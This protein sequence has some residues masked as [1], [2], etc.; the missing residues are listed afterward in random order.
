MTLVVYFAIK[1][2][3]KL[4]KGIYKYL[5]IA[6]IAFQPITAFLASYINNDSTALL[7][8]TIIIYL[9]IL[10]LENNW[11]T[12]HCILLGITIGFCLLTYYNAYGYILCSIIICLIS[13]I[14]N[15]MKTK[16]IVQKALIVMCVAFFNC[17]M[18]V[19]KECNNI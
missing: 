13:T 2:S 15:K 6:F 16:E 7:A 4:F 8:S 12:K 10:G 19:Y 1:I 11:K 18:V 3:Q 14:S 17:R 5:F 9:W